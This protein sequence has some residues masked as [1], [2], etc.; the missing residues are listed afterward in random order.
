M[1]AQATFS[2]SFTQ[3]DLSLAAELPGLPRWPAQR[4]RRPRRPCAWRGEFVGAVP[5]ADIELI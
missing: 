3:S 4:K 1:D 5:N 2:C